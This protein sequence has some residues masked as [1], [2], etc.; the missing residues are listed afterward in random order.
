MIGLEER[1]VGKNSFILGQGTVIE[2]AI[3]WSGGSMFFS[4]SKS[5]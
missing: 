3:F 2:I 4:F 1:V 5:K